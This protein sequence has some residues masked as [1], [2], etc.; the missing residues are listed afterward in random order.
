MLA[1]AL[2]AMQC[3]GAPSPRASSPL[4][5][6]TKGETNPPLR[7]DPIHFKAR[8]GTQG[9]TVDAYDAAGLFEQAAGHFQLG[10]YAQAEAAYKQLLGE[11]KDSAFAPASLYNSGLCCE[12]L[13]RFEEAAADYLKLIEDYSGWEN[14]KDA[15]FRLGGAYEKL[16][17]W[18]AAQSVFARLLEERRSDLAEIEQ[19]EAMV[20]RGASLVRLGKTD[21]AASVLTTA[22]HMFYGDGKVSPR[23]SSYFYGMAQFELG[24]VFR[25]RM[26][27]VE[28]PANESAVKDALERKCRLLLEAQREYTNA[29]RSTHP[30]WAAAAAYSIG[31]LYRDLWDDMM[32][33]PTPGDLDAE[34]REIYFEILRQGIRN[35]LK[36]AMVQ[37]ERTIKMARR[38]NMGGE[39][40]ER[41]AKEIDEIREIIKSDENKDKSDESIRE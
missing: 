33:A 41:T 14:A 20:R 37:W 3:S 27:E 29:I 26:R 24:E 38:L 2:F 6:Q 12:R 18:D 31:K 28:L 13:Q 5:K 22:V 9:L 10:E 11:F 4:D 16:A 40:I 25:L 36:K 8:R 34:E 30:H 15:F 32:K 35:L 23:D 7:L 19:V 21:D 1:L 39:W 17:D